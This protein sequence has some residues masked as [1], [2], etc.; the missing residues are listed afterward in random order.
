[1]NMSFITFCQTAAPVHTI[2]DLS[3]TILRWLSGATLGIS[4]KDLYVKT[5]TNSYAHFT[6]LI[7]SMFTSLQS[8]A[9]CQLYN[10]FTWWWWWWW[11][12]VIDIYISPDINRLIVGYDWLSRSAWIEWDF[13]N[14]KVQLGN[15]RWLKLH[16]DVESRRI[17]A[18]VDVELPP[19]QDTI[20][21][22]RVNHWYWRD[23]PFV[24]VTMTL[25]IPNLSRVYSERSAYRP[26]SP[27]SVYVS[28][29]QPTDCKC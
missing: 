16:D 24:V 29:T 8:V 2:L 18:E 15:S 10:K 9:F 25:K 13:I 12:E 3:I 27:T 11:W 23:F 4:F 19:R 26:D 1:M 22:V 5:C 6:T 28:P 20:A 21:P 7:L 17:Y 14:D